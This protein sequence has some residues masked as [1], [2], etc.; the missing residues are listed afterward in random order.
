MNDTI[1]RFKNR[2]YN[3]CIMLEFMNNKFSHNFH[4]YIFAYKI[5]FQIFYNF[6]LKVFEKLSK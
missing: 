3:L 1:S 2:H 4:K 5:I 6:L